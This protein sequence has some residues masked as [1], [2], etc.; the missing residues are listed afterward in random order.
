M[1]RRLAL[2]AVGVS[3]SINVFYTLIVLE[4]GMTCVT[5]SVTRIAE[6]TY[7]WARCN[8]RP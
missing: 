8:G 2:R 3:L 5:R 4:S 1:L 6:G 7:D